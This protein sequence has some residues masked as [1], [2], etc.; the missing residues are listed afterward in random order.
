[1]AAA[2]VRRS[3]GSDRYVSDI[4]RGRLLSAT[5]ALVG[6]TGFEGVSARRVSERAGVSSR[7]F[8]EFFSDR[9]DCFLAAFNYAFDGLELE[10]RE[11]W[12]SELGWT[13]RVRGALTALLLALDREPAVRRLVFVE[14]LAA[15]P[16]VLASRA[17]VLERLAVVVDGGRANANAPSQL[18]PLVAEGVVGGAFGVIH[19]RLLELHPKPLVELLGAL[20]AMIVLPYRGSTAAAREIERPVPRPSARRRD[21][22]GRSRRPL[23]SA[24]PVDY[25]LS[26]R[27]QMALAAVAG[28]PGLSNREVSEVIGL[29]DQG[30]ISR[31]MKRLSE[32]GLVENAQAHAKRLVRA[33]RLTVDGEAVIDARRS[34]KQAQRTTSKGGKLVSKSSGRRGKTISQAGPDSFPVDKPA[35]P[36]GRG[37]SSPGRPG[38]NPRAPRSFRLTAL[39]HEVLAQVASLG[40]HGAGRSNREVARAAGVKDQGQISKL[41]ARLES[42]G[43]LENSGG[44]YPAAGNAWRLTSRGEELLCASS[45]ATAGAGQ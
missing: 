43:L 17:R 10:V 8:Y 45:P 4:Q 13:A 6:E 18:P 37:T 15:G 25:R 3:F 20:M 26:V 44:G 12:E 24:S 39:T 23:G 28:R 36:P 33:W 31:M 9:E 11:G 38:K 16:R 30:Q 41:L 2:E 1:M 21:G 29:S 27:T 22:G 35:H 42:H 34:L 32:Q 19:A 7:T 40:E 5:F 14:A